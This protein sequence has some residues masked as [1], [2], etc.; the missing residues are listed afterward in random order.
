MQCGEMVT[1]LTTYALF[2]KMLFFGIQNDYLQG[3]D[4]VRIQ[5]VSMIS[6]KNLLNPHYYVYLV[7]FILDGSEKHFNQCMAMN[8]LQRAS[9]ICLV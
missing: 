2:M 1:L 7:W 4:L 3:L 9:P 6:I 5:L 8:T